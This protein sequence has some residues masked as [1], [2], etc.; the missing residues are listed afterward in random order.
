MIP[1][2]AL[3]SVHAVAVINSFLVCKKKDSD[4]RDNFDGKI[5][6]IISKI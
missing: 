5:M 4:I 1:A 2:I 3:Q 6:W